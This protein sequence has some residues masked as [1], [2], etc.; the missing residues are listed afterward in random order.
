M[1]KLDATAI[2]ER[3]DTLLTYCVTEESLEGIAEAKAEITA[4][5]REVTTAVIGD[6]SHNPS[7][8][9]EKEFMRVKRNELRA[10]QRRRRDELLPEKEKP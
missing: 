1:T 10:E 4:L 7:E 9:W 8:R 2:A 5:L 3:I 6:D